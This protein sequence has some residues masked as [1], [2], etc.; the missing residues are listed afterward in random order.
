MRGS[1]VVI[2]LPWEASRKERMLAG[3]L[4]LKRMTFFK[5]TNPRGAVAQ[6]AED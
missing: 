5:R 6:V 2:D 3:A 4:L 1:S